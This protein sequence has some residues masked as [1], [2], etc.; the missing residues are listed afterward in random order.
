MNSTRA[1]HRVMEIAK[2]KIP[3]LGWIYRVDR[4]TRSGRVIDSEY[5]DWSR[6]V[7]WC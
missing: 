7:S 5:V 1:V 3:L 6:D 4:V 2:D